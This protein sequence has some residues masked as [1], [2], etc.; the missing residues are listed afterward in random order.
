MSWLGKPCIALDQCVSTNDEAARLA[1]AGAVHG[2]IVVA[3]TQTGG[4]GRLGR[5]WTS[6]PGGNLYLSC[7]LRPAL[8]LPQTPAL[9][10]AI[11][12]A[13]CDAVRSVGAPAKL[14]WPNDVLLGDRKVAGILLEAQSQGQ[15]LESLIVGIGVNLSAEI[16]PELAT[17]ATTIAAALPSTTG[18]AGATITREQFLPVL[19][20]AIELWVD[21]Y[22]AVGMS[23]VVDAW[24]DRMTQG[25]Q[26]RAGASTGT[27]AGTALGIDADGNLRLRDSSEVIHTIRAGDVEIVRRITTPKLGIVVATEPPP[28][29]C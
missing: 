6:P 29:V 17:I 15:R 21:R 16:A 25:L 27:I 3:D 18:A 2:T 1:R 4:R 10:L 13:V 5:V 7:V 23:V 20:A 26:V 9:A 28:V 12:I 11:G 8:A 14:K 24:N 22:V 19:L